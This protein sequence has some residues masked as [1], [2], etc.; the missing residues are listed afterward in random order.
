M[1][2]P[3]HETV[4]DTNKRVMLRRD[5]HSFRGSSTGFMYPVGVSINVFALPVALMI[6]TLS[7]RVY[8][9]QGPET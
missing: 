7:F 1:S 2:L 9:V 4:P 3:Y 8:Q 5:L 6:W